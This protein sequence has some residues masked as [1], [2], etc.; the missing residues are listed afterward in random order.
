V[1]SGERSEE[2]SGPELSFRLRIQEYIREQARPVEKFGHQPRLYRLA[3]Q[4]GR[5]SEYDDDVV[6]AAAWLHDLGVFVGHRP[7]QIEALRAWDNVRYAMRQAP[8]VLLRAGFPEEKIP[9]VLEAIR[10]HQPAANPETF[11]GILLRDADILE[12]LGSTG[13]L[14]VVAKIGRDTRYSTFTD[15]AATL[16]K[17][18]GELPGKIRL[19]RAKEMAKPRIAVLEA[20]L[21]EL[22]E[23]APDDLF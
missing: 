4:I 7:E 3:T 8:A 20:F 1:N 23:E 15:A 22:D 5:G 12:Q 6:F 9:A 19:E 10:T 2:N 16:R 11:E 21:R 17:S 13:I 18:L 14:R